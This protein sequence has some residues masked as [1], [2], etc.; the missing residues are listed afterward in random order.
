MLKFLKLRLLKLES[1]LY[2]D[3]YIDSWDK[4]RVCFK[5]DIL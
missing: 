5:I 2:S 3:I 4:K 1:D